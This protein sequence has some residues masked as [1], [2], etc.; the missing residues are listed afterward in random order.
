MAQESGEDLGN[1]LFIMLEEAFLGVEKRWLIV[2]MFSVR[3]AMEM[4]KSQGNNHLQNTHTVLDK[5][6]WLSSKDLLV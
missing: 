6:R 5:D 1:D 2:E 4:V 3:I